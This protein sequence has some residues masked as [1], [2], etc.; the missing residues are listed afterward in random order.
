MIWNEMMYLY[1]FRKCVTYYSMILETGLR[2]STKHSDEARGNSENIR[3]NSV[4]R[5]AT[6]Y[7]FASSS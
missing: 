3:F 5:V 1:N 7:K 6:V 2:L 4:V